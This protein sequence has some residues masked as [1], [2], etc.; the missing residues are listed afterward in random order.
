MTSPDYVTFLERQDLPTLR[1]WSLELAS[2]RRDVA[3]LW[4]LVKQLP[5]THEANRDWAVYDPIDAVRQLAHLVTHFRD[6]AA[7]EDEEAASGPL[8]GLLRER[9]IAYLRDHADE[10]RFDLPDPLDAPGGVRPA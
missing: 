6:E 9:Y 10:R 2:Q 4:D 7:G 8:A 3:F 1:D 5:D